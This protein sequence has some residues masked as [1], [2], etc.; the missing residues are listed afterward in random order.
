[1]DRGK[2][3]VVDGNVEGNGSLFFPATS[4]RFGLYTGHGSV[5][6]D[7]KL[8]LPLGAIPNS[9]SSHIR[10]VRSFEQLAIMCP[11]SGWPQIT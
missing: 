1:M 8:P 5:S 6:V 3:D 7:Y 4:A 11:C 9:C 2:G 10:T